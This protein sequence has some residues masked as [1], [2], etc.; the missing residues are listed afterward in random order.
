MP[1]YTNSPTG[2]MAL[3]WSREDFEAGKAGRRRPV[4]GWDETGRP[5]TIDNKGQRV[6]AESLPDFHS[7]SQA[8]SPIV[9]VLPGDGWRVAWKGAP[10][11]R[12]EPVIGWAVDATGRT[13]PI[14]NLIGAGVLIPFDLEA[15]DDVR[16]IP[17]SAEGDA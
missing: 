16:L 4:V 3:Y 1:N 14:A 5:L 15:G 8:A 10:D 7:V 6:A 12:S 11:E 17:P 2:L 13:M 9:G